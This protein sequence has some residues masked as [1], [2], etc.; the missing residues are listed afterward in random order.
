MEITK[1]NR[2][3]IINEIVNQKAVSHHPNSVKFIGTYLLPD[4]TTLWVRRPSYQF[5]L[6]RYK[7]VALEYM[8]GGNL[9]AVCDLHLISGPNKVRLTEP[10]IAYITCEVLKALSYLHSKHRIHRDIKTDNILLSKALFSF[11]LCCRNHRGGKAR[12]LWLCHST[13]RRTTKAKD[14]H[15]NA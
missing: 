4:L 14:S 3:Y 2:K 6:T 13:H 8:D 9:T 15:W 12:R 11:S 5:R 1:K 7:K 10:Q